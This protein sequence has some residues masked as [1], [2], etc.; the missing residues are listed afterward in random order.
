MSTQRP[1]RYVVIDK[2]E[3]VKDITEMMGSNEF[4]QRW[5]IHLVV[6][7]TNRHGELFR[8]IPTKR[9]KVKNEL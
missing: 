2:M 6:N 7:I 9:R 5:A 4:A 3:L 1:P 8:L